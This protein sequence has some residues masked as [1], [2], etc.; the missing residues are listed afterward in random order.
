MEILYLHIKEFRNFVHQDFNFGGK[1]RFEYNPIS[2]ELIVSEN[3][4]Y[5]EGFYSLF[6][7]SRKEAQISNLSGII[8]E[9]GTGKSSILRFILRNF[10]SGNAGLEDELILCV[11]NNENFILYHTYDLPIRKHN[12]NKFG[13]LLEQLKVTDNFLALFDEDQDTQ[14]KDLDS[15]IELFEELD[16]IFFSNSFNLE[17]HRELSGS[18]D[19]SS[20]FLITNDYNFKAEM[21]IIDPANDK[22]QLDHFKFEEI[23]RQVAFITEMKFHKDLIPFPL[24]EELILEVSNDMLFKQFKLDNRLQSNLERNEQLSSFEKIKELLCRFDNSNSINRIIGNGYL[25][26][27]IDLLNIPSHLFPIKMLI[28]TIIIRI[29]ETKDILKTVDKTILYIKCFNK[30]Q[31]PEG[32]IER[33]KA[34]SDLHSFLVKT[35][36]KE[37]LD[38]V[39]SRYARRISIP[40]SEIGHF[41]S[42]YNKTFQ[43]RPY[44]NLDWRSLSSG[45]KAIF[46]MYARFHSL[47]NSQSKGNELK[48]NL[49]ILLDEPDLYLHPQWQKVILHN[50]IDF[51][52]QIYCET[53]SHRLRKIQI[54]FTTNSPLMISDLL[55]SN[56]VFLKKESQHVIVSDSLHDQKQT[57]A[58]NI[59]TLFADSFFLQNGLI[60]EIASLKINEI[61]RQLNRMAPL[62][63]AQHEKMRKTI[64]QIGEP[65]IKT[66][67]IQMYN[68]RFSMNIHE[69][70]DNI[71]KRLD[72][73]D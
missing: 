28:K 49:T 18:R 41:Y 59:H 34:L 10:V 16:F 67:L 14:K 11:R 50:L 6:E 17:H 26:L 43:L 38:S 72:N 27:M 68:D 69:R 3:Y 9:N 61:I 63:Q 21:S 53:T 15:K 8:G 54:F 22:R 42:M 71:E 40:I 5:I 1:Y 29:K 7:Q 4:Q 35:Q 60:G 56:S 36:P 64:L 62:D 70:I 45:E 31:L 48:E 47:S 52:K 13:I 73:N 30:F 37:R 55:A 19:I 44:L 58:A 65:L 57:F 33:F 20:D 46:S 32:Y 24:P 39:F 23:K 25:N 2:Q 51:L 12:L 66:K